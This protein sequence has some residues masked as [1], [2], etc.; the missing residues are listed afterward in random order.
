MLHVEITLYHFQELTPKAQAKAI[1]DHRLF[2]LETLQPD[3]IDGVSDWNDPEKMEMY[4][5]EIQYL[6]EH[7]EPVIEAIEANEYLFHPDGDLCWSCRYICGP[8]KGLTEIK[9]HGETVVVGGDNR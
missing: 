4:R 6:E 3:Y 7:D 5:D 1:S 2:L 8:K 9:I